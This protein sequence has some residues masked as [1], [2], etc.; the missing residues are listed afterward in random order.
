MAI[1]GGKPHV[2]P[3]L[4]AST[5]T[6]LRYDG[7]TSKNVLGFFLD[8][9]IR[10]VFR[11]YT[12]HKRNNFLHNERFISVARRFRLNTFCSAHPRK[13]ETSEPVEYTERVVQPSTKQIFPPSRAILI[14][15]FFYLSN[16][17]LVVSS[18]IKRRNNKISRSQTRR[19]L[20]GR[21]VCMRFGS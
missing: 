5:P 18:V 15:I 17:T 2:H 1:E 3:P 13:S 14:T 9:A 19:R 8:I 7:V 6:A 16:L 4:S 12:I 11:V 10:F 21:G 20:I